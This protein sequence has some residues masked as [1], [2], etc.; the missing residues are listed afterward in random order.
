MASEPVRIP[1]SHWA[2]R[3]LRL[4]AEETGSTRLAEADKERMIKDAEH[5]ADADK[6][7]RAEAEQLNTADAVCY[8]AEKMMAEFSDK[9]TDDLR[10]RL[11]DAL[12]ETRELVKKRDVVAA[13]ASAAAGHAACT[14]TPC[15]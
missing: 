2:D 8:Q 11:Q 9:L 7:R 10:R 13:T 14:E 6:Q 1:L 12:N 3:Q 15:D 4:L 5:Y